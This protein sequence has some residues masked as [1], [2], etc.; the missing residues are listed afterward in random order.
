MYHP[1]QRT[2]YA[3]L[4]NKANRWRVFVGL[5]AKANIAPVFRDFRRAREKL[6]RKLKLDNLA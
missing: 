3:A 4:V 2:F 1:P 5:F 6:S